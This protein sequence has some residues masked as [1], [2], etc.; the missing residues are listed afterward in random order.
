MHQVRTTQAQTSPIT[1]GVCHDNLEPDNKKNTQGCW[2]INLPNTNKLQAQ[3]MWVAEWWWAQTV[4]LGKSRYMFEAFR[5]VP[6][7]IKSES[8]V[9][10]KKTPESQL[11]I[12]KW[13][14]MRSLVYQFWAPP[15]WTMLLHPTIVQQK[16]T[17]FHK[18]FFLIS[19]TCICVFQCNIKM[20]YILSESGNVWF[21]NESKW[22]KVLRPL[23]WWPRQKACG[24]RIHG[25]V[26]SLLSTSKTTEWPPPESSS[27]LSL[28]SWPFIDREAAEEYTQYQQYCQKCDKNP[29]DNLP[30]NAWFRTCKM[31]RRNQAIIFSFR[32]NLAK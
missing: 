4:D 20:S 10:W 3:T 2:N 8:T 11:A 12:R 5:E 7:I 28:I 24:I 30:P 15:P 19:L 31:N 23:S 27:R 29:L 25:L 6:G 22:K 21:V 16:S 17:Q 14:A 18:V 1:K 13:S 32:I 9:M 26:A